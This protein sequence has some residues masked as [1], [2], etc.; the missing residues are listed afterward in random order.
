MSSQGDASILDTRARIFA[1][2]RAALDVD[3]EDHRGTQSR[4][5]ARLRRHPQGTIPLRARCHGEQAIR[6]F[7]AICDQARRRFEPRR[8]AEK[9]G[10]RDRLLSRLQQSAAALAHGGRRRARL[11]SVEGGLGHRAVLRTGRAR[12]TRP[13]CRAPSWAPPRPARCSWYRAR[14][15]PPRSLSCPRRTW[16]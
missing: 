10:E 11:A 12:A 16:C 6:Q 2:I 3:P 7:A 14:T 5:R 8:H 4:R 13:R 1:R 15:I 9:G